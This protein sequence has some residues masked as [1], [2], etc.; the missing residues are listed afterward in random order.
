MRGGPSNRRHMQDLGNPPSLNTPEIA[1][2]G[3]FPFM[4]GWTGDYLVAVRPERLAEDGTG[5]IP[6]S[7]AASNRF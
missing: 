7:P 4:V 1:Y 5:S 2:A 3:H 6:E